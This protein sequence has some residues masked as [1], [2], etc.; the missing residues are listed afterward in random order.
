MK[1]DHH[2]EPITAGYMAVLDDHGAKPNGHIKEQD[3]KGLVSDY[4][5]GILY[6]SADVLNVNLVVPPP[7]PWDQREPLM[8][9][10]RTRKFM[11]TAAQRFFTPDYILGE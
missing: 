6:R 11:I 7:T 5:R 10:S 3:L 9:N 2:L 1:G 4:V 8:D